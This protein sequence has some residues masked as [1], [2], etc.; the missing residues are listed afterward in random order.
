MQE[1]KNKLINFLDKSASKRDK[2]IKRNWYY[3]QQIIIFFKY[4]IPNNSSV[5]EI[6]CA[7]GYLLNSL[8]PLRGV[9]IDISGKKIEIAQQKYPQYSFYQGDAE[10]MSLCE[11][12]DYI[13]ISDTL[14]YFEDIQ[15][16]F[17]NINQFANPET[18]IIFTYQNF[19]WQPM[20]QFAEFIGLKMKQ[21]RL[22]WLNRQDVNNLL[23]LENYEIVSVGKFFLFPFYIPLLSYLINKYIA[24]LPLINHL[25]IVGYSIAR[26]KSNCES[27][28]DFSVSVIIPA[29]NES[30]NIENAVNQLPNLG[31][32]TEIVFVEGNSTDN[33]FDE[34][35]R[36]A[37]KYRNSHDIKYF[38][39]D[40]K[41]KGDAVRKGF[42]Y[43]T[44]EILMILDA[45][46][47]VSPAELTKFYEAIASNKGEFINGSRLIYPMEKEAMRSLNMLG[48]K[49]FSLMFT[50]LLSQ[51]LKDTL[52]GTKVLSKNNWNKI[53]KNRHY[54][55]NFDPFGDFDLIFGASKL[56]LKIVEVPIRYKARSYGETNIN[57]FA[58]GWLLIKMVF[59]AL[60]KIKF[61]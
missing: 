9:G 36:I 44:G 26:I 45:D 41:G 52:C 46:L 54:F 16:L 2:Y 48:N 18:R 30:G 22:N 34:I 17:R 39:Q 37:E 56:G 4:F 40:G 15:K 12:F 38:K 61:R 55:G 10:E 27:E 58:H 32:H 5:I 43:A 28:Q 29:R 25:C 23:G 51:C 19:L 20:L 42:E 33:T 50:W 59:F 31:K 7:T 3:Y 47:T 13:V 1:N 57:R 60:S 14:G 11:K 8:Q 24:H 35:K 49:F 21:I 6:G 53:V